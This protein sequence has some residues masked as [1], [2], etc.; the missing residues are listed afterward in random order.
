[1]EYFFWLYVIMFVY[2]PTSDSVFNMGYIRRSHEKNHSR[3]RERVTGVMDGVGVYLASALKILYTFSCRKHRDQG[4][5]E[6]A[7]QGTKTT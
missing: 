3:K 5:A 2:F 7:R 1:M 4:I 6:R